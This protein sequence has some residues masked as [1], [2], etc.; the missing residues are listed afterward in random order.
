MTYKDNTIYVGYSDRA[1]LHLNFEDH[2]EPLKM[3]E[4]G[5]YAAHII[6]DLNLV[7]DHYKLAAEGDSFVEIMDDSGPVVRLYGDRILVYR[8]GL[9]G[10]LIAMVTY[11]EWNEKGRV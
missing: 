5:R 3:G 1:Q 9:R 2:G 8:A 6:T 10:I 4:D 11:S 7:P